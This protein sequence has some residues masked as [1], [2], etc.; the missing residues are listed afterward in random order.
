MSPGKTEV[1]QGNSSNLY[2]PAKVYFR[3]TYKSQNIN[4]ISPT[5]KFNMGTIEIIVEILST[6]F[7]CLV[8]LKNKTYLTFLRDPEVRCV[9]KIKLFASMLV[10]NKF[11]PI[12]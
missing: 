11:F 9:C 8:Q 7:Q 4:H 2:P 12:I 6:I 5:P 1:K 3:E 10:Y